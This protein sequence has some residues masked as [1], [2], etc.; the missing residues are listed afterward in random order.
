MKNG[1]YRGPLSYHRSSQRKKIRQQIFQR[2]NYI[3]WLCSESV[4][5]SLKDGNPLA[6]TLDHVIARKDGGKDTVE[7]LRLA[8]ASCNNYRHNKPK[9]LPSLEVATAGEW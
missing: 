1:S 5:I 8:H 3:C 6:P 9:Q 4:D 7:N 2:D